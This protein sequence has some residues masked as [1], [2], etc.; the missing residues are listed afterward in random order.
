MGGRGQ[1]P[2]RERAPSAREV[3]RGDAARQ[4]GRCKT[5]N[6]THPY[7]ARCAVGRAPAEH[8]FNAPKVH[9]TAHR[10]PHASVAAKKRA[11]LGPAL[12]AKALTSCGDLP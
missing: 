9:L 8:T 10:P 6:G 7:R 3:G 2:P 1:G 5:L 11:G 12:F 4:N